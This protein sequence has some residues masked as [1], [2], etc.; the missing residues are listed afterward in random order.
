MRLIDA[1]ALMDGVVNEYLNLE[2]RF[3]V[4]KM[5][6]LIKDA[7][8]IDKVEVVQCKDCMHFSKAKEP[9]AIS[10]KCDLRG[11]FIWQ[12]DFCSYGTK[13]EIK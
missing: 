12:N 4:S 2:R 10:G 6:Q 5:I 8:T 11:D 7:P 1:D 9:T 3:T 13:K